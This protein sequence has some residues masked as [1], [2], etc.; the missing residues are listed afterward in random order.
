MQ[1]QGCLLEKPM[2]FLL[3]YTGSSKGPL[4]EQRLGLE[5]TVLEEASGPE[6]GRALPLHIQPQKAPSILLSVHR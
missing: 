5:T 1:T 4:C 2:I 6:L 3:R